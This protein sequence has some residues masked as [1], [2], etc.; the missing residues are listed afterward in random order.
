MPEGTLPA[1]TVEYL[2]TGGDGPVL[3]FLHGVLTDATLW[4]PVVDELAGT[5]RCVVPTLPLGS[6]RRPLHEDA[7]CTPLGLAD[8]LA[9]LVERLALS[10]VTVVA[11][12]TGGALA[13]LW[14]AKR[15]DVVRRLVLTSCDAFE[16]FP[17]GLPGRACVAAA[18]LPGGLWLAGQTLRAAA[19]RRLPVTFGWMAKRPLS[20]AAADRWFDPV[21]RSR[22]VRRDVGR[23]LR[24]V[25]SRDTSWAAAQL[26]HY[27]RPALVGW[28]GED[29]VMPPAHGRRLA[30]LLPDAR[31]VEVADSY[32]LLPWDQPSRLAAAIAEFLADTDAAVSS[33]R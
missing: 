14:V 24:A 29:R 23:F 10:A 30:E 13:Q 4:R 20:P 9:E 32:T 26:P 22:G 18:Y 21:R 15:P 11:N 16:N 1:G 2:D 6:H 7:D 33:P 3:L 8:L 12:D 19:L 28:A 5:Y 27:D 25:S 17:P 31:Y